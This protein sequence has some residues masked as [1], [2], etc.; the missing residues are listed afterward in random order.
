VRV[1]R[2]IRGVSQE[3]LA[4]RVGLTFQQIQ[5]YERGANRISASK[6]KAISEALGVSM[7]S[8]LGESEPAAGDKP[9]EWSALADP[10]TAKLVKFYGRLTPA[11]RKRILKVVEAAAD[12]R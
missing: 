5:K 4:N 3:E 1:T 7:S 10:D 11:M 6:L 2:K 12:G 8:L 9:A